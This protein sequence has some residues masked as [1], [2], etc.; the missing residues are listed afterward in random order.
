MQ[1]NNKLATLI[2]II[3]IVVLAFLVIFV[4]KIVISAEPK[5]QEINKNIGNQLDNIL[6]DY[7]E[8]SNV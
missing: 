7:T 3:T 2:I 4:T 5:Q 8:N 6:G 1:V